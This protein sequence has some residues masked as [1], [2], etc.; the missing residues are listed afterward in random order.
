M[1][2]DDD[3]DWSETDFIA[4]KRTAEPTAESYAKNRSG[5]AS[6]QDVPAETKSPERG[7]PL[8]K[9]SR[10]GATPDAVRVEKARAAAESGV[11]KARAAAESGSNPGD[12]YSS[13]DDL[14]IFDGFFGKPPPLKRSPGILEPPGVSVKEAEA[15]GE[16]ATTAKELGDFYADKAALKEE[17]EGLR[18]GPVKELR[19]PS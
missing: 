2:S 6:G 17:I 13:D 10:V 3:D 15:K 9:S 18:G 1:S 19:L 7:P 5:F 16:E 4:A 8:A 11:E 14:E 12:G